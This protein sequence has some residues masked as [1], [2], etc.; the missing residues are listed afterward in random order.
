[1]LRWALDGVY[2]HMLVNVIY[3]IKQCE[4]HWS[5]FRISPVNSRI[6]TGKDIYRFI[7]QPVYRIDAFRPC[8]DCCVAVIVRNLAW[9]KLCGRSECV[10]SHAAVLTVQRL[11]PT[12]TCLCGA[13]VTMAGSVMATMPLNFGPNRFSCTW[14]MWTYLRSSCGLVS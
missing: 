6:S 4:V 8:V 13:L 7:R 3:W 2:H 12:G 10:T 11:Y 9:L 14:L 5:Y 1:M